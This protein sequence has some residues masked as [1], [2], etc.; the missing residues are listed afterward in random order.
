MNILWP[1]AFITFKE[2]IRNRAMYGISFFALALFGLNIVIANMAPRDV[3]KV[4]VDV[5]LSTVSLAGLLLV[6][7]VGIN[8]IAKDLDK[9]TIYM[10]LARPL[11]REQY[12]IGKFL[13]MCLLI[14]A[15]VAFLGVFANLSILLLK[16]AYA[17]YFPRFDW[18][19]VEVALAFIALSLIVLSALSFFFS[20]FV[21]SSFVTLVLTMISY[22][23]GQSMSDVKALI[24]APRAAGFEISP[25]TAT[26]VNVAYYVLP[27]LSFFDIKVHAAHGIEIGWPYILS[28]SLYGAVYTAIA[29]GCAAFFFR[30]KEF[31]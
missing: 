12:I 28:V 13:G 10:V 24:E 14:L 7:F 20:S 5:A 9:R 23:I 1:L 25:V 26:V 17:A 18:L 11:S 16:L 3:G 31:P 4:A 27:N 8:L 29:V 15:T 21:S 2:G 19:I 22:I 6:L 30:K